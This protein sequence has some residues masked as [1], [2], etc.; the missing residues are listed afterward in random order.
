MDVLSI[1]EF[2][3]LSGLFIAVVSLSFRLG[4]KDEKVETHD[5]KL[6]EHDT[7]IRELKNGNNE[8]KLHLAS[9]ETNILWIKD[10]LMDN[11]RE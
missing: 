9:I 8:V 6:H 10:K 7:E 11:R 2:I 5:I 3:M 4:K 1:F